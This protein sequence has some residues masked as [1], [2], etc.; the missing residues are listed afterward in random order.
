M[1]GTNCEC[2]KV[3]KIVIDRINLQ[4]VYYMGSVVKDRW[5]TTGT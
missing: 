4:C 1:N 5:C 2:R 3:K